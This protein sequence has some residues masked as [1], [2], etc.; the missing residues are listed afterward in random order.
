[1][2]NK[3]NIL[4]TGASGF[5]GNFLVDEAIKRNFRVYVA[6]RKSTNTETL[7]KKQI[8]INIINFEDINDINDKIL[9]LPKFDY[10][11][12]NAGITKASKKSEFLNINFHNTK[13]FIVSLKEMNKIPDKFIYISSLAAFGPTEN[14]NNIKTE[15][16]PKPI[17][18]YGKSKLAAEKYIIDKSNIPYLIYRPTAVYGPGDSAFLKTIKLINCG[19]DIKIGKH[20]Q[21]LTFIYVKDL[22]KLIFNSLESQIIN[23]SYFI[24]DG[25]SYN[26][27][28]FSNTISKYSNKKI[29][30]LFLPVWFAK[31][32]AFISESFAFFSGKTS[33]LRVD[34]ISEL[35]AQNWTCN[36]RPLISDLNFKAEYNLETGMQETIEWYKE[37]KWL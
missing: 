1:M 31:S 11:I 37:N 25:N 27:K 20:S 3:K 18:E 26:N 9:R 4:I 8:H 19:W 6:V 2:I 22:S 36:T 13:N 30:R 14:G 15:N 32:I 21:I 10:I 5:I 33:F 7:Q 12:H 34:K 35:A 24:S 17:S 28:D 23:K 29:K 16:N